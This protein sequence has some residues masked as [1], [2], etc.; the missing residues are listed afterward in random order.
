DPFQHHAQTTPSLAIATASKTQTQPKQKNQPSNRTLRMIKTRPRLRDRKDHKDDDGYGLR[1]ANDG[2]ALQMN[3]NQR[4]R[5]LAKQA[6]LDCLAYSSLI[7]R[8]R[9]VAVGH[10]SREWQ[11]WLD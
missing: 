8:F 9:D 7:T 6:F 5:R 4:S 1:G 11:S 2:Q 3:G 10:C